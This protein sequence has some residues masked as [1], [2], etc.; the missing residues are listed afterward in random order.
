MKRYDFW[1]WCNFSLDNC[2]HYGVSYN[3]RVE[4]ENKM[5]KMKDWMMDMEDYTNMAI[6]DHNFSTIEDIQDYVHTYLP[7]VDDNFVKK[8]AAELLGD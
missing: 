8:Y 2:R 6:W 7:V 4:K 5:S 1:Y 3:H